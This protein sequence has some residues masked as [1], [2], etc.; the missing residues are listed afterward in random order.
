MPCSEDEGEIVP[1]SITNYHFVDERKTPISF[2]V[3]PFWWD[4]T[5]RPDIS[6]GRVFVHGVASGHQEV[7]NYKQVTSWK[8]GLAERRPE[9][10]VLTKGNEWIR[11]LKPKK[12]YLE[13][14]RTIMITIHWLHFLRKN[15]EASAKSAW[16]HLCKVF[17]SFDVRPSENDLMNHTSWIKLVAER[18]GILSNSKLLLVVLKEK[19]G[20][21]PIS[22]VA[23]QSNLDAK[24]PFT[25][26]NDEVGK[27][28]RDAD[29]EASDEDTG[30]F[31]SVCAIC[32]DGGNILWCEG[33]CLRSFHATR[34]ADRDQQC[35]SLGY[36]SAEV[37][38]MAI[39]LCKNCQYKQHQCFACGKLGSSDKTA[40]PK[41]FSCA[42][43]TCGRFYHPRCVAWLLF[44]DN[45]ADATEFE[46]QVASGEPFTCP[47]H[48]CVVCK[49]RE[50][51]KVRE[52][53]FAICRRCPKSY[54]RKCLPR[55]ISFKSSVEKGIMQ[56]AW[57]NLPRNRI[58]IYCLKHEIDKDLGTPIRNH[59][60]F[61]EV[62]EGRKSMDE[63]EKLNTLTKKRKV[64]DNLLDNS[65]KFFEKRSCTEARYAA[66]K[67]GKIDAKQMWGHKKKG[68][69]LKEKTR[70]GLRKVLK[71][72]E[73]T[74]VPAISPFLIGKKFHSSFPAAD[75]VTKKRLVALMKEVSSTLT[76][77]DVVKK[78]SAPSTYSYSA[79][80]IDKSI[81][82]G[83]V[84]GSVLAVRTALQKLENGASIEDA[85]AVCEPDVVSQ[86]IKWR[87][88]L[89]VYLAPFLHGMRYT[90]FGRHFTKVEKLKEI[91]DTLQWYV[92]SGDMIVDFCC[93]AND[94]SILM[95]DK[96]DGKG[97]SFKNYDIMPAKNDFSF[98]QRDWMEVQPNELPDGSK[99]VIGLNPPFG[100]K[101]SLANKF[102]EKALTFRPK[103]LILIVPR[104]TKRVDERD[105]R[106]DLIWEDSGKLSGKSFYLPGSVAIDDQ[107]IEQWNLQ[108]PPLSLWSHCNW[109]ER[110]REI[111]IRH[112]HMSK[113]DPRSS[114]EES[115][116]TRPIY[117][118][119][120]EQN[121]EIDS[122]L[123]ER[124]YEV[125]KNS[126]RS[127]ENP[128]DRSQ[129]RES[130]CNR[131]VLEGIKN[132]E[133]SDMSIL[134][135]NM[136]GNGGP[137]ESDIYMQLGS[138]NTDYAWTKSSASDV[139]PP[140]SSSPRLPSSLRDIPSGS[141]DFVPCPQPPSSNWCSNGW[142][143]D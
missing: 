21:G 130:N 33:E 20:R 15:P 100:V 50:N 14:V 73:K 51:K 107:Q 54:H 8:L 7:Y 60:I 59:I 113:E 134:H 87:N 24:T 79:R 89:R 129:R 9:I 92:E 36:S 141:F 98:E 140:V 68:E 29:S 3:L 86:I 102:I 27:G 22:A 118:P 43:A 2:S 32:D 125:Q 39:F 4:E 18:D 90:S 45:K 48:T 112:G 42:S 84:E 57:N 115:Q 93:G 26:N 28:I 41:V 80:R 17:C 122:A 31:N 11:L 44:P 72:K 10:S 94:F 108:P 5:E 69:I 64:S 16:E 142:L 83:K 35:R 58:L 105:P 74:S 25:A 65:V 97:C 19:L 131:E 127:F 126:N 67:A 117:A 103:L 136:T 109:T 124:E 77:E 46:K 135:F 38:A 104:E 120:A 76:L 47:V 63:A 49:Q 139:L 101:A 70:L 110:H 81:T 111:A 61:P 85:K 55:K 88:H 99:L 95:K 133:L 119:P 78:H 23:V 143:N 71:G 6:R 138:C 123:K 121:E 37:Q 116:T 40:G 128:L 137:T 13:R 34:D 75:G 91:V 56:R 53:Q 12:S 114:D 62:L 52:L 96:L 132:E 1:Q 30:L 106:Y 66:G 82:L